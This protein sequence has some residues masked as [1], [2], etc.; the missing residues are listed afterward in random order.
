MTNELEE[1]RRW[2][3]E[4]LKIRAPVRHHMVIV[5]AFASV[6]R[7]RFLGP[8]PWRLLPDGCPDSGFLTPDDPRWLYHDTLVTIDQSRGLNNGQPSLWAR[9]FDQLHW[10]RGQRVMQVG[11]GTG[12]YTAVLAE[13]VGP[14]GRVIAV[15]YD[16]ELAA[17][18]RVNLHGWAQVEVVHGDGR[19]HDP[20]EVDAIIVFA[21]STHPAPLWLDRLAASGQLLMPLTGENWRGFMIR[22]T[23]R[24]DCDASLIVLSTARDRDRFDAT[25]VGPIGFFPCVGGR[26]EQAAKRLQD[27][28]AEQRRAY[29]E[30][31]IEALHRGDPSS[32]VMD[33]VWYHGP[34]FW[35]ERK[36]PL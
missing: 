20:G 9:C 18:A 36:R 3:A 12:Y 19:T 24:F 23:R 6:P 13:I 33:K 1:W 27:A 32:E 16:G 22:V 26:D 31:P 34:G 29:S 7:E 11:A 28:L 14:S 4:D 21:G 25:S 35:L 30:I 17:K 10:K 8:G 2:Y 15:E 5:E